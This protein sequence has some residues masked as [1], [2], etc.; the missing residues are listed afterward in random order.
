MNATI[1]PRTRRAPGLRRVHRLDGVP[2]AASVARDIVTLDLGRRHPYLYNARLVASELV[3]NAVTHTSSGLPGGFLTLYI[4]ATAQT[5][6]IEVADAGPLPGART[7]PRLTR[8]GADSEHGRGLALVAAYAD[9]W[10]T[11]TH[12]D[13]NRTVWALWRAAA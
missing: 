8:P 5:A 7:R 1:S 2:E 12:P 13:G 10:G 4:E 9:D 6:R 11:H 3:T